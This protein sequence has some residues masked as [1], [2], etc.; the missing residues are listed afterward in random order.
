MSP[1]PASRPPAAPPERTAFGTVCAHGLMLA[2]V[3]FFF[4]LEKALQMAPRPG[5]G[6]LA[7]LVLP[8]LAFLLA[9]EGFWLAAAGWRRLH[10]AWR[11]LFLTAHGLVYAFG[12]LDHMWFLY[13]GTRLHLTL[14]VYS[15]RFLNMLVGL[16]ASG[17]NPVLYVR[18]LLVVLCLVLAFRLERKRWPAPPRPWRLGAAVLALGAVLGVA[19]WRPPGRLADVWA[20]PAVELLSLRVGLPPSDERIAPFV[21]RP[22]ELYRAPQVSA[23][24]PPLLAAPD[25]ASGELGARPGGERPPNVVVVLLESTRRDVVPPY[26]DAKLWPVS[27]NLA[28]WSRQAVVVDDMYSTVTHTSKAL[29]GILCGTYPRLTMPIAEA[30]PDGLPVPCLPSLLAASGYRTAFLQSALA[31]FENRAGLTRNMGFERAGFQETLAAG[32]GFRRAGYLGGD[33]LALV[34]PALSWVAEGGEEPFFLTLLTSVTHHPY[35]VPDERVPWLG[36]TRQQYL[37]AIHYQDR[38]VG[39]LLAGLEKLGRL[40]DTVVLILGDHGEAFGEHGRLQHDAVPYQ[41]VA[42]VPFLLLGPQRWIGPPRHL[43]GL[44]H[45]VDLLP[46]ILDLAGVPWQGTLPGR[47]LLASPG[48][49][50]VFTFCWYTDFCAAMREPDRTWIYHFGRRA[51]EL[52]AQSDAEQGADLADGV[53]EDERRDAEARILGEKFSVDGLWGELDAGAGAAGGAEP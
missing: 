28:R 18:L 11:P 30:A 53:P 8:E 46:T 19:S 40:D 17:F 6:E 33:D 27:P 47:D 41:E 45:Q 36:E 49:D 50:R 24:P 39:E 4:R 35:Q 15:L 44:R 23:A 13:T 38:F 22:E 29:V 3:L 26:A 51:T 16:L 20:S 21:R 52:Y 32:G 43:G 12:F 14:F 7:L 25:A 42:H 34:P 10:R 48:H 5:A 37:L 1:R 2:V 9:F 31:A